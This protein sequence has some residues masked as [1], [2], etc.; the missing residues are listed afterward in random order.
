MTRGAEAKRFEARA[1][2]KKAKKLRAAAQEAARRFA[3]RAIQARSVLRSTWAAS[4]ASGRVKREM[5][6]DLAE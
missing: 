5:S 1:K 3:K 4:A 6:E 2:D